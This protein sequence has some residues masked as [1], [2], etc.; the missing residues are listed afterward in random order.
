MQAQQMA[1]LKNK[2]E[3]VNKKKKKRNKEREEGYMLAWMGVWSSGLA[4]TTLGL[5]NI[6]KPEN[7]ESDNG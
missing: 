1:Q 6:R 4:R 2:Q 3:F 7:P 5:I